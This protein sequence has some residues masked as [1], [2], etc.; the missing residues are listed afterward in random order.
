[1]QQ[2]WP[3]QI[4]FFSVPVVACHFDYTDN[5]VVLFDV[6]HHFWSPFCST[7]FSWTVL[8]SMWIVLLR[9][10]DT[11]LAIV[12]LNATNPI[13]ND[14][15]AVRC[16]LAFHYF[17]KSNQTFNCIR[18]NTI[19]W[20][21]NEKTQAIRRCNRCVIVFYVALLKINT[22]ELE[23][24]SVAKFMIICENCEMCALRKWVSENLWRVFDCEKLCAGK[25][26]TQKSKNRPDSLPKFDLEM[27][28]TFGQCFAPIN[29]SRFYETR[30]KTKTFFSKSKSRIGNS[31]IWCDASFSLHCSPFTF[32]IVRKTHSSNN[33]VPFCLKSKPTE[34]KKSDRRK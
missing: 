1:M 15:I 22:F 31:F 20:N 10:C 18:A 16:S 8:R 32:S 21:E 14:S 13:A 25:K 12:C 33:W 17:R 26:K 30:T 29:G 4:S 6:K 2:L 11:T 19:F 27:M 3:I 24:S 23:S 28:V 34:Q 5:M 9:L 7:L